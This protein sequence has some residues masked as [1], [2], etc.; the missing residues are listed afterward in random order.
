MKNIYIIVSVKF[1]KS[2]MVGLAFIPDKWN[3]VG[4]ISVSGKYF[5]FDDKNG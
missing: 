4:I 2:F 3:C 5:L 1:T